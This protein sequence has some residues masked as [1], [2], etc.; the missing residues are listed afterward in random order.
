MRGVTLALCC[1]NSAG[2]LTQTLSHIS[3]LELGQEINLE[4]LLIDNASTDNT[5]Q[6]A[7]DLWSSFASNVPLH[8]I[9]ENKPGLSYARRTAIMHAN[10]DYILFCDDDNWLAAD[11]VKRGFQ[12]LDSNP[13]IG[14]L[15]GKGMPVIEGEVP[16][17]FKK[18]AGSYAVGAQYKSNSVLTDRYNLYGAGVWMRRKLLMD[19]Y[20]AGFESLLTGRKGESLTSGEDTE[21]CI[22][23]KKM[24]YQLFYDDGLEFSHLIPRARLSKK[25]LLKRSYEKGKIEA[26]FQIYKSRFNNKPVPWFNSIVWYKEIVKRIFLWTIY[27]CQFWSFDAA[28]KRNLIYSSVVFRLKHRQDFYLIANKIDAWLN[29]LIE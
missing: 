16:N 25:Y 9:R 8:I 29:K 24:G 4:V 14:M 27:G 23:I 11:Y 20:S 5:A 17:W 3:K 18:Y 19:L 10:Y 15:G 2:R 7:N 21:I 6:V 1:Y 28:V 22:W 26:V 12:M 13:A